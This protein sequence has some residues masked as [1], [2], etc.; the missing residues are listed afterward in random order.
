M[1]RVPFVAC[2]SDGQVGPV[3]APTE[4]KNVVQ[5]DAGIAQRLAYYQSGTGL[6]VLAPRGWFCFGLY[7]SGGASI[8]VTPEPFDPD[9][10]FSASSSKFT[11]QVI[12]VEH[13]DGET[14]G[15]FVV[16]R[17]IARVF[18]AHRVFVQDVIEMFDF[19]ATDLMFGPYPKDTLIYRSDRVVEYSTPPNS[20]GL[21]TMSWLQATN[22]SI[23]GVAILEGSTPDFLLLSMRLPPEMKSLGSQVIEQ[24]EAE[25]RSHDRR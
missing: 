9:R 22:E 2:R 20:E 14:S 15:R 3:P 23:A 5:V 13:S 17:V 19:F 11:G 18:P 21:G 1:V 6:G 7:G 12:A 10:M 8:Y 4:P 25:A 24:L 16:A